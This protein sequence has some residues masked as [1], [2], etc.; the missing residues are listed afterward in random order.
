MSLPHATQVDLACLIA[1]P[2]FATEPPDAQQS[3][4]F[5]ALEWWSRWTAVYPRE[6]GS[7]GGLGR[8]GD[9]VPSV[10]CL[11]VCKAVAADYLER[12]AKAQET[13]RREANRWLEVWRSVLVQAASGMAPFAVVPEDT[14]PI[15]HVTGRRLRI[16]EGAEPERT[17]R[18]H[19]ASGGSPLA[20]FFIWLSVRCFA[21][22]ARLSPGEQEDR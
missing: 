13:V 9:P 15:S 11:R 6:I 1:F 3:H 4:S 17:V 16:G 7:P 20:R 21:I 8:V 19:V 5:E 18:Y 12:P 10:A 2:G 14:D 22:A